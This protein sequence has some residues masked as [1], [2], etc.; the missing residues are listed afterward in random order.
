M[1]FKNYINIF[2]KDNIRFTTFSCND[3][4]EFEKYENTVEIR[5]F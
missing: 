2:I 5:I 1:Y 4:L 3:F